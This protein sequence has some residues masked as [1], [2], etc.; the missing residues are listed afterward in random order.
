MAFVSTLPNPAA[1]SGPATS[2]TAAFTSA[3][4]LPTGVVWA[5]TAGIGGAATPGVA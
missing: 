4:S 3:R 5:V 2:L 1:S